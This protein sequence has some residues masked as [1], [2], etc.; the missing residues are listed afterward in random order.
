M[1]PSVSTGNRNTFEKPASVLAVLDS[2]SI[3]KRERRV[4]LSSW[5]RRR[6][7]VPLTPPNRLQLIT[8]INNNC[9]PRSTF[10]FLARENAGRENKIDFS[11]RSLDTPCRVYCAGRQSVAM[12]QGIDIV[13][14]HLDSGSVHE[15][16]RILT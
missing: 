8:Q 16:A 9:P 3:G 15:Q 7:P 14:T 2:H 4:F 6:I 13:E 10:R 11:T 1:I 12:S 5:L